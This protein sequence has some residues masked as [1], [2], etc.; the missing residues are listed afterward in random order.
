MQH[1]HPVGNNLNCSEIN[2]SQNWFREQYGIWN[3]LQ[4]TARTLVRHRQEM[5]RR[6]HHGSASWGTHFLAMAPPHRACWTTHGCGTACSFLEVRARRGGNSPFL[7]RCQCEHRHGQAL[8]QH[9]GQALQCPVL[10]PPGLSSCPGLLLSN[11]PTIFPPFSVLIS[12]WISGKSL[13]YINSM[14]VI[15]K[16]TIGEKAGLQF[17]W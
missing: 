5:G 16:Q 1:I 13:K 8:P 15:F 2:H 12:Q 4:I 6:A 10:Q 14:Q 9:K 11:Q 17:N 7:D 3:T